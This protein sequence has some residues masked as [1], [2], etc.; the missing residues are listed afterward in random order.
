[1]L[2]EFK[3]R[4]TAVVAVMGVSAVIAAIMFAVP[5]PPL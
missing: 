5:P 2:K 3:A 1:M 4:A